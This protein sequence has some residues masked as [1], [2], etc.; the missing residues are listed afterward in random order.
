MNIA[1]M[2]EV[3]VTESAIGRG[4][5]DNDPVRSITQIWAPEGILLATKDPWLEEE[6]VAR[7]Y[8]AI[9]LVNQ[10]TNDQTGELGIA[11][12]RIRQLFPDKS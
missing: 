7:V 3:I 1:R 9:E 4:L 2:A 8:R 5:T 11:V 10:Q 6:I 12:S